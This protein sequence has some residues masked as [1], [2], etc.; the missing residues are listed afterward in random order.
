MLDAFTYR[1]KAGAF[2][3]RLLPR[4]I[5]GSRARAPL[6]VPVPATPSPYPLTAPSSS[7]SLSNAAKVVAT[8][9]G[10]YS[11]GL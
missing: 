4:E 5:S 8:E 7:S 11:L 1:K 10:E 9:G 3:S 6:F 2:S